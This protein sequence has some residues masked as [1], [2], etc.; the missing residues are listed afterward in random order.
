M[1]LSRKT[2]RAAAGAMA[3]SGPG[4]RPAWVEVMVAD[5]AP[6]LGVSC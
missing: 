1:A 3:L 4:T 2:V 6:S 5:Q